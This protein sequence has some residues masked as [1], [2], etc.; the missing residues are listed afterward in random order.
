VKLHIKLALVA[1]LFSSTAYVA[2][3]Q[4]LRGCP[5]PTPTCVHNCADASYGVDW[6][7]RHRDVILESMATLSDG[8][9]TVH[10][11][12][13]WVEINPIAI[14]FTGRR[15]SYQRELSLNIGEVLSVTLLVHR[16]PKL[17]P[18]Q[19]VLTVV[20]LSAAVRNASL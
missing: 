15:P 7:R 20:H 8:L 4:S 10:N 2:S 6:L 3:A 5:P 19:R 12:P 11:E 9:T 16:Y 13:R 18:L 1:T 14:P 17:K